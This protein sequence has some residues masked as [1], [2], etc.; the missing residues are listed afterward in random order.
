[1]IASTSAE[2]RKT[3]AIGEWVAL[4]SLGESSGV[5]R[6]C[7]LKSGEAPT[8]NQTWE[9]GEKAIWVCVRGRPCRVPFLRR[10]QLLQLQFHCGKPPPAADPRILMRIAGLEYGLTLDI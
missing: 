2:G 4:G 8:R 1:M 7:V 9:S 5:A 10:Q 6:I 3:P